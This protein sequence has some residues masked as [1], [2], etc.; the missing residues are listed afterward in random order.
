MKTI[1]KVVISCLAAFVTA[2]K[3]PGQLKLEEMYRL[4]SQ[5]SNGVIVFT[6]D[7]Y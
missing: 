7:Q 1:L 2:S 3:D 4:E 6:P 5:A